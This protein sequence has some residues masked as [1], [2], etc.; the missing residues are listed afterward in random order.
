MLSRPARL[1]AMPAPTS[2]THTLNSADASRS[3]SAFRLVVL[4][5]GEGGLALL[6]ELEQAGLASEAALVEP[7]AHHHEQLDW[8][9]VGTEGLDKEQT[10][11]E[12]RERVPPATT[13]IQEGATAIDP[14]AQTVT[15]ESGTVVHYDYLVVALGTRGHWGRIR[16]LEDNL[17]THGICSVYG[18]DEA[19]TAWDVIH[20]FEGGRALFT[21]PSRPH[22]GAAAP[23]TILQKAETLWRETGVLA[24]TELFF[25]TSASPAFA[26]EAYADLLEREAQEAHVHVYTGHDLVEVR[27]ENREAVFVVDKGASQSKSVLPYDLLHVVPPMRPPALL[28]ESGLA[29]QDGPLRGYLDVD[30][31]TLRHRRF[32]TIFGIGDA[33]GIDGIKTGAR[34]RQQ[35][36]DV[37]RVLRDLLPQQE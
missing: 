21:A 37:G 10:R 5:G 12:A 27:P 29:L 22:K 24:H 8:M 20:S 30:P 13:W 6:K 2:P 14:D 16:G 36:A 32:D 11:S 23:L 25:T 1:I 17:G 31:E 35:A 9:R 26:G 34:A 33:L 19:E 7:S 15:T 18:Y 3:P 4:G 28:H